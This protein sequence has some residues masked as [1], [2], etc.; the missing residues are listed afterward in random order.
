ML[1]NIG[2]KFLLGGLEMKVV[3]INAKGWA[4]LTPAEDDI[5]NNRFRGLVCAILNDKGIDNEGNKGIYI[6]DQECGAV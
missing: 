6:V 2:N 5:P 1:F 3:F 4:Y